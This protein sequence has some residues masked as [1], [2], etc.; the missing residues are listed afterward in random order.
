MTCR[1][2][3]LLGDRLRGED[4][5]VDTRR[6]ERRELL[7]AR[8]MG[9]IKHTASSNRSETLANTTLGSPRAAAS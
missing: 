1:G 9:P 5:I 4:R 7:E 3:H 8:V 2:Y 6:A